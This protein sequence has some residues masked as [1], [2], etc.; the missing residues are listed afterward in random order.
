MPSYSDSRL[1]PTP[2]QL[3]AT[4][5]VLAEPALG[6]SGK[7][8]LCVKPYITATY[9]VHLDSVVQAARIVRTR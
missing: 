2:S 1:T 3:A 5:Y 6:D 8:S 9:A 7:Q 4:G